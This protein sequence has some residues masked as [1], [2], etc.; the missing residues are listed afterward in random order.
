MNPARFWELDG[1]EDNPPLSDPILAHAQHV[2]GVRLPQ[3]YVRLLR[4]RNGGPTCYDA[5]N[6]YPLK[7]PTRYAP[8]ARMLSFPEMSGIGPVDREDAARVGAH[9]ILETPAM[10]V[11]WGLP[12]GLVLLS[13]DGHEWFALDYRYNAQPGVIW[14]ESADLELGRL[15]SSFAEFLRKL[16]SE[17]Q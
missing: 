14:I 6:V 3:E 5:G 4:V 17:P 13:G 1:E 16:R 9:D 12:A 10:L 2:L 15:A 11:E 7:K 8:D